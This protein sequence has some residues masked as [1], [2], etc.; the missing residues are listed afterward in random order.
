[1][2]NRKTF[3]QKPDIPFGLHHPVNTNSIFQHFCTVTLLKEVRLGQ[4]NISSC[5]LRADA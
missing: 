5:V 3:S 2:D 4:G 1:M